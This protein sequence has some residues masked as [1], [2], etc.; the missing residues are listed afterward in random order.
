MTTYA[1][2]L[3]MVALRSSLHSCPGS[4]ANAKSTS[5]CSNCSRANCSNRLPATNG[6]HGLHGS[7]VQRDSVQ[8]TERLCGFPIAGTG[9]GVT[10]A[11][12]GCAGCN[13]ELHNNHRN[14]SGNRNESEGMLREGKRSSNRS[15]V[16]NH[17][18]VYRVDLP[19]E[20]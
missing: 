17:F 20:T 8:R 5:G 10:S 4:C 3:P 16:C 2:M 14:Q 19:L 15:S 18:G 9:S 7:T 1:R 12:G 6:Q 11:T 13:G